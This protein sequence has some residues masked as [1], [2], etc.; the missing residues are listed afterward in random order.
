MVS[1]YSR[2]YDAPYHLHTHTHNIAMAPGDAVKT[3]WQDVSQARHAASPA[4][5]SAC[6]PYKQLR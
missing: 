4:S 5:S 1:V 2:P 6:A 3:A